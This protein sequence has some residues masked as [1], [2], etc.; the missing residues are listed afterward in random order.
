ME[1]I[2][3]FGDGSDPVTTTSALI[4]HE[5]TTPGVRNVNLTVRDNAGQTDNHSVAV[6]VYDPAGAEAPVV[7]S[8]AVMGPALTTRF[9]NW[10]QCKKLDDPDLRLLTPTSRGRLGS[11]DPI[12]RLP[13]NDN[14]IISYTG[15]IYVDE[16]GLYE[17]GSDVFGQ[18]DFYINGDLQV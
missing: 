9:I 16:G 17:F 1:Y 7:P 3:N 2:W 10:E 15:Y 18:G 13:Y 8:R 11:P 4:S 12:A 6:T 5:F 14:F